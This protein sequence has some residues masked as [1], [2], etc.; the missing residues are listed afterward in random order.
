MTIEGITNGVVIDHIRAGF[1]MKV[2]EYLGLSGRSDTVAL[3]MNAVSKKHGRKDIIKLENFRDVDLA[4]I[5]LIDHT[6]TVN[7]IRD[8][9]I[10]KKQR[11]N[12]PE[13]V[14][15]VLRCKNP[16]C[17]TSVERVEHIFHLVP[18]SGMYRCDYCDD[19]VNTGIG[20]LINQ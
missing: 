15:N 12:L 8:N 18:E 2:L 3:I 16:R 6:A 5:G 17:V 20:A 10:Y 19:L 14:T 13:K 9:K 11:L 1:G 4:V 7:Y